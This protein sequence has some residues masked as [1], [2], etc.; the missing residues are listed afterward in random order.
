MATWKQI[1]D[2][3]RNEY[4]LQEDE[5]DFFQMTFEL[6]GD[7][8]QVIFIQK[9]KSEFGSIWMQISSPI[10]IIEDDEINDALEMMDQ[11]L[12]GGMVKIGK[13]HFVRHNMLIDELSPEQF[14]TIMR[15]VMNTADE[16]EQRFIGSDEN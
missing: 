10:G 15:I 7:R 13:R 14:V 8:S 6:E 5:G 16:M 3:I 2:F 9:I 1:K 12:C 11:K 4:K